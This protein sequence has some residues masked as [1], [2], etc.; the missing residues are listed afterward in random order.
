MRPQVLDTSLG[1]GTTDSLPALRW[2]RIDRHWNFQRLGS[3]DIVPLIVLLV[4]V[5]VSCVDLDLFRQLPDPTSTDD[6]RNGSPLIPG[7]AT[8]GLPMRKIRTLD[9][10]HLSQ[11]RACSTQGAIGRRERG[12]DKD[13]QPRDG[14]VRRVSVISI[15]SMSSEAGQSA[16]SHTRLEQSCQVD[17]QVHSET[18]SGTLASRMCGSAP[19]PRLPRT[20]R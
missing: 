19:W 2:V 18:Q 3:C 8:D 16:R 17:F 12:F 15:C 6:I 5:R 4:L 9:F 14:L 13:D 20:G 1:A 10:P 11:W 7:P